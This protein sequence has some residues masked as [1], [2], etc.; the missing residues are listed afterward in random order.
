MESIICKVNILRADLTTQTYEFPYKTKINDESITINIF[1]MDTIEDLKMKLYMIDQ[2][3]FSGYHI[4]GINMKF[5]KWLKTIKDILDS[6]GKSNTR[7]YLK[8]KY[9]EEDT[10]NSMLHQIGWVLPSCDKIYPQ[11]LYENHYISPD[12]PQLTV[13]N[14]D[15]MFSNISIDKQHTLFH[16]LTINNTNRYLYELS[17]Q[18]E[19]VFIPLNDYITPKSTIANAIISDSNKLN[20]IYYGFIIKYFMLTIEEF[21]DYLRGNTPNVFETK[22][23]YAVL[24]LEYLNLLK[25]QAQLA[26]KVPLDFLVTSAHVLTKQSKTQSHLILRNLFDKCNLTMLPELQKGNMNLYISKSNSQITTAEDK[27]AN[28]YIVTKTKLSKNDYKITADYRSRD[29]VYVITTTSTRESYIVV[30]NNGSWEFIYNCVPNDEVKIDDILSESLTITKPIIDYFNTMVKYFAKDNILHTSAINSSIMR[31]S[32][33]YVWDFQMTAPEFKILYEKLKMFIETKMAVIINSIYL[34]LVWYRGLITPCNIKIIHGNTNLQVDVY[35]IEYKSVQFIKEIFEAFIN[36]VYR[37]I[38]ERRKN[39]H[40]NTASI[41]ASQTKIIKKLKE[42]DP[43]LYNST[44]GNDVYSRK[45]QSYRQPI[46]LTESEYNNLS[47]TERERV[48]KYKNFTYGKPAY[49]MCQKNPNTGEYLKMSYLTGM[50]E[51]NWCIPCCKKKDIHEHLEERYDRDNTCNNTGV[52][53]KQI[54]KHHKYVLVYNKP[55]DI[56]RIAYIPPIIHDILLPT[57]KYDKVADIKLNYFCYG[58]PQHFKSINNVGF[59]YAIAASMEMDVAQ[60]IG[61][62][63]THIKSQ[64]NNIRSN[65]ST[66]MI[67]SL[68][69]IF[70]EDVDFYDSTTDWLT[71]FTEITLEIFLITIIIFKYNK[72]ELQFIPNK[73]RSII[74]VEYIFDNE[75]YYYPIFRLNQSE[76]Y[77]T[78]KIHYRI[79]SSINNLNK[80]ITT[81]QQFNLNYVMTLPYLEVKHIYINTN[82]KCYGCIVKYS[83]TLVYLPLTLSQ[84]IPGVELHYE[85]F[86][87]SEIPIKHTDTLQ[88]LAKLDL[89]ITHIV[90]WTDHGVVGIVFN[91][92]T[93]YFTM[94]D[95]S[96]I[97]ISSSIDKSAIDKSDVNNIITK[98]IT[99]DWEAV[100]DIIYNNITMPPELTKQLNHGYYELYFYKLLKIEILNMIDS[101]KITLAKI[102]KM[103]AGELSN[104]IPHQVTNIGELTE[105][106]LIPCHIN[107]SYT[108]CAGNSLK[109]PPNFAEYLEILL[110]EINDPIIDFIDSSREFVINMLMFDQNNGEKIHLQLVK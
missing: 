102:A 19:F 93:C 27:N 96:S 97:D 85:P 108:H 75:P 101:N 26:V 33:S 32:L 50:H 105:N 62:I 18:Y 51:K 8:H 35:D 81:K 29:L 38:R 92:L 94:V 48:Y 1:R 3:I 30:N 104:L 82:N 5:A 49:Y 58:V 63:I 76:Y 9:T 86:K 16:D 20:Y 66:A 53:T 54:A 2:K 88:L 7:N 4:R 44:V 31:V 55:I 10:L 90:E 12:I 57:L 15:H 91:G 39:I 61:K 67:D 68:M 74:L 41:E 14:D 72:D 77:Q 87:T 25:E 52:Y 71:F 107:N 40:E 80:L 103:T 56:E 43:K 37:L 95:R 64:K 36:Y 73:F 83:G 23:N 84:I 70:I 89:T 22:F 65:S 21:I 60:Y 69:S 78:S 59:V 34:E 17:A 79:Y 106:I 46:I 99:Y 47:N 109:V 6:K 45:C 98:T 24:E 110:Y 42:Q 28:Y 100:N 11:L 13:L